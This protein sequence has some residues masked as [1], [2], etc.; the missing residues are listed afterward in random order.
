VQYVH[1][2]P[3]PAAASVDVYVNGQIAAD[4]FNFRTATAYVPQL[5]N[6]PNRVAIAPPTSSSAGDALV[7]FED[8]VFEDGKRYVVSVNGVINP[9][10]FQ[11]VPGTATIQTVAIEPAQIAAPA[12]QFAAAVV[13]GSPDAPEVDVVVNGTGT[14]LIDNLAFAEATE[15]LNVPLAEYILNITPSNDN[16]TI[17]KSYRAPLNALPFSAATVFA[18]G[19]LNAANQSGTSNAFG[20]WV[21]TPSGGPLV[22][23]EEVDVATNDLPQTAGVKAWPNPTGDWL[24]LEYKLA[25][26]GTVAFTLS[27]IRG[28]EIQRIERLRQANGEQMERLDLSRLPEGVYLLRMQTEN[29]QGTLRVMV[30]RK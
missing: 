9:A 6:F 13:H 15:F 8:V 14:P 5:S 18:S 12:G 1:N 26:T 21:A 11:G 17:V 22:P 7:T 20:L 16:A 10:A 4:N 3:D 29:A 23:L 19:F 30:A 25:E 24:N 27:D 2:S 28:T